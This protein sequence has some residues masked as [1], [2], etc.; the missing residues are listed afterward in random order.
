MPHP[1]RPYPLSPV[2][3][4]RDPRG[5]ESAPVVRLF[6][7]SEGVRP[8]V[9]GVRLDGRGKQTSCDNPHSPATREDPRTPDTCKLF[10]SKVFKS[11]HDPAHRLHLLLTQ[12]RAVPLLPF[13]GPGLDFMDKT[14]PKIQIERSLLKIFGERRGEK[15]GPTPSPDHS[16]QTRDRA[17]TFRTGESPVRLT[18][19]PRVEAQERRTE[20][21]AGGSAPVPKVKLR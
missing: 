17:T 21:G 10:H 2:T 20:E 11:T 19:H 5:P 12:S 1:L 13:C 18:R 3:R 15:R 8:P 7:R 4:R 9:R 6:P 16:G 14:L